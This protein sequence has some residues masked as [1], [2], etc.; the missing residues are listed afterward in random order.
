MSRHSSSHPSFE[1]TLSSPVGISGAWAVAKPM[2]L[3]DRALDLFFTFASRGC[4]AS[5][6]SFHPTYSSRSEGS[7]WDRDFLAWRRFRFFTLR[8]RSI[9]LLFGQRH[10]SL[11]F[12]FFLVLPSLVLFHYRSL[13]SISTLLLN[14]AIILRT[15][16]TISTLISYRWATH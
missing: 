15:I 16:L 10:K 12:H 5:P 1:P 8:C 7:S 11:C 3:V 9:Y 4:E 14:L 2:E 13:C 6:K